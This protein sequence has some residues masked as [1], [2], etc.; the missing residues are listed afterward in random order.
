MLNH[1]N[2]LDHLFKD[3]IVEISKN[4]IHE[5]IMNLLLERN[6]LKVSSL[7]KEERSELLYMKR[8]GWLYETLDGILGLLSV[9]K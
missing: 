6:W 5:K 4:P 3:D 7:N 8:Q 2:M 9:S 1:E